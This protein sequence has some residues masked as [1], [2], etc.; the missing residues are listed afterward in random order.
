MEIGPASQIVCGQWTPFW[1]PHGST[2]TDLSE[3]ELVTLPVPLI[4]ACPCTVIDRSAPVDGLMVTVPVAGVADCPPTVTLCRVPVT[5]NVPAELVPADPPP[6][7]STS[8]KR[9]RASAQALCWLLASS[10]VVVQLP[11]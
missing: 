3:P 2:V 6:G 1:P 9:P 8:I 11:E 7:S 4:A 10:V 5:V